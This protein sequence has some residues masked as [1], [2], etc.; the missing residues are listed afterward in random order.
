[1]ATCYENRIANWRGNNAATRDI[2]DGTPY[3]AFKSWYVDILIEWHNND[4][5]SEKEINRNNAVYQIQGN[6]NPYIDHPEWVECVWKEN[7]VSQATIIIS[8]IKYQPANPDETSTVDVSAIVNIYGD[9]VIQNV[10]LYYGT[11]SSAMNSNIAMTLTNGRYTAQIPTY[12]NGTTVYFQIRAVSQKNVNKSSSVYSYA[13]AQPDII[14][15]NVT[16]SPNNP[17]STENVTVTADIYAIKDEI[18]SVTLHWTIDGSQTSTAMSQNGNTYTASIPAQPNETVVYYN[19]EATTQGGIVKLSETENYIVCI[20]AVPNDIVIENI[21]YTPE[22]PNINGTIKISADVYSSKAN[23]IPF[24]RWYDSNNPN[25]AHTQQM[26][27]IGG[28][29]FSA[30]ISAPERVTSVCFQI[31]A[32]ICEVMNESTLRCINISDNQISISGNLLQLT[33]TAGIARI[34]IYNRSGQCLFA[35]K[36]SGETS[37]I[38]DV[39]SFAGGNYLVRIRTIKGTFSTMK[40]LL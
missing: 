32:G 4:P 11:S 28:N 27:S 8:D 31:L 3:P 6:R 10:N 7:C 20:R 13:E 29:N 30:N 40:I 26:N 2:L 22:N 25:M 19:I 16:R 33:E 18:T 14:I 38:I 15:S 23:V 1:M 35:K 34:E 39:S 36:Y 21:S 17:Q 24:L 9:D 37:V 5:V 12:A